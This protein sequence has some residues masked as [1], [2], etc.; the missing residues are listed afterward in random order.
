MQNIVRYIKV[1]SIV[2]NLNK[3]C[4][5]KPKTLYF[6]LSQVLLLSDHNEIYITVSLACLDYMVKL[7]DLVNP[8]LKKCFLSLGKEFE[9]TL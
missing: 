5:K 8:A 7:S 1:I 9:Q 2:Y 3:A 4:K 6:F